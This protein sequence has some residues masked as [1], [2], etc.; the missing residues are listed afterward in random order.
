MKAIN[1]ILIIFATIFLSSAIYSCNSQSKN[2]DKSRVE[3]A[4]ETIEKQKGQFNPGFQYN[5]QST[6]L[7]VKVNFDNGVFQLASQSYTRRPGKLPYSK[8]GGGN[9][10]VEMRDARNAIIGRYYHENPTTVR[11]CEEGTR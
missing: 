1:K 3:D 11:V 5:P 9:F 4:N 2:P 10:I 7:A 6:H 8:S